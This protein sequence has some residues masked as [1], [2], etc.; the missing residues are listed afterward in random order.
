MEA[1]LKG[2]GKEGHQKSSRSTGNPRKLR[3]TKYLRDGK[4]KHML[5]G[6]LHLSANRQKTQPGNRLILITLNYTPLIYVSYIILEYAAG[7]RRTCLLFNRNLARLA[8]VTVVP[9]GLTG[10]QL[11]TESLL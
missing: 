6:R 5:E 7:S 9:A 3:G 2:L 4:Y 1:S 10:L 8:R 11:L